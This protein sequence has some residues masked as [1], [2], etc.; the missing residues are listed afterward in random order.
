MHTAT[1]SARAASLPP[2]ALPS[3][4]LLDGADVVTP[5][6]AVNSVG[7]APTEAAA[8]ASGG[9]AAAQADGAGAAVNGTAQQQQVRPNPAGLSVRSRT[10]SSAVALQV[11]PHLASLVHAW[12]AGNSGH[13]RDCSARHCAGS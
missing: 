9:E 5:P 6:D 4:G 3:P 13:T 11:H 1:S 12:S 10:G 7:A 8:A 2:A